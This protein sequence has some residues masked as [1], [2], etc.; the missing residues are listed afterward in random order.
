MQAA[1]ILGPTGVMAGRSAVRTTPA[2][3]EQ[4]HGTTL[5]ARLAVYPGVTEAICS[6]ATSGTVH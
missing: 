2:A 1:Q 6:S 5:T 4:I 3:A